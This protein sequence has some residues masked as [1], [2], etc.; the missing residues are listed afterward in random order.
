MPGS[1][2]TSFIPK[3]NPAKNVRTGAKR[4]VFVGTF[5]IRV[6]FFATLLAASGVYLYDRK[7]NS[8]LNEEIVRLDN[9]IANFNEA[10]LFRVIEAD[11][12][13]VQVKERLKYSASIVS[14]LEALEQ[15]TISIAEITDL[16]LERIDNDTFEVES[17]MKTN[18][19]DSVIFQR[20]ILESSDKLIVSTINDLTLQGVPPNNALYEDNVGVGESLR[21]SVLFKALLTVDTEKIPHQIVTNNFQAPTSPAAVEV[22]QPVVLEVPENVLPINQEGI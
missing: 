4:Q 12:R 19:F 22:P 16:K 9:A 1:S 13:I 21:E 20:E 6:L 18:T 14:I 17:M 7:L 8:D 11:T 10:E 15:S 2:N 3:R 5:V